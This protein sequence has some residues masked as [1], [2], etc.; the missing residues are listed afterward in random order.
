MITKDTCANM[1]R[2][3]NEI[4]KANQ[5]I[6]DLKEQLEKHGDLLLPDA[7]GRAKGL[8]LGVPSGHDSHRLFDVPPH[9]AIQVIEAHIKLHEDL[10]VKYNAHAIIES[11]DAKK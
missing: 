3:Y 10:L 7:F 1:W 5:L 4:E 8:Q 9:I 2:S 6:D 11:R